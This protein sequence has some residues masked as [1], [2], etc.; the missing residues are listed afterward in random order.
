LKKYNDSQENKEYEVKDS[1]RIK[2][3]RDILFTKG[4][5]FLNRFT[6]NMDFLKVVEGISGTDSSF[7][8]LYELA[9]FVHANRTFNSKEF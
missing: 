2:R 7:Q 4:L 9:K 1:Y 8:I 3:I 6:K 5:L